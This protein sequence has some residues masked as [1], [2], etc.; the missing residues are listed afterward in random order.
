LE[1]DAKTEIRSFNNL[2]FAMG[3]I[4]S[5]AE[6]CA[7][8]ILN[9]FI[10]LRYRTRWETV[11][12][13]L[14]S[15]NRWACFKRRL[16]FVNPHSKSNLHKKL[17]NQIQ[18]GRYIYLTVNERFV[19]QRFCY[20]KYDHLHDLYLNGFDDDGIYYSYAYNSSRYFEAQ[21]VSYS[22]V[23]EAFANK[24]QKY[25]FISFWIKPNYRFNILKTSKIKREL[26]KYFLPV[27]HKK[28][29]NIYNIL[30]K[31]VDGGVVDIKSMRVLMEHMWVMRHLEIFGIDYSHCYSLARSLLLLA[32]KYNTVKDAAIIDKIKEILNELKDNEI[33]SIRP[34]IIRDCGALVTKKFKRRYF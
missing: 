24:I 21:K 8:W 17:E 4:H 22:D 27:S 16:V 10:G 18:K 29:I 14:P 32:V 25:C 23:Y 26:I 2:A 19:P 9:N 11:Y 7:P 34:Y 28:G 5:F 31:M 33:N 3:V 20:Q 15:S 30:K 13:N 1:I 12:F 6:D